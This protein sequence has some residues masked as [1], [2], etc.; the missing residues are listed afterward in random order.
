MDIQEYLSLILFRKMT[1]I[2]YSTYR[3]I[4]PEQILY[5]QKVISYY[6]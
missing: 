6:L 5:V 3:M 4:I 1:F 2:I